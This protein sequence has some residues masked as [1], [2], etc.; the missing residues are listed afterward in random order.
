MNT[1]EI[2]NAIKWGIVIEV[3]NDAGELRALVRHAFGR[4]KVAV[5]IVVSL[6]TGHVCTVWK[7]RGSD[8][9]KTL[10]RTLYTWRTNVIQLIEGISA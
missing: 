9:H 2:L 8:N 7:N 3:H 4:P 1:A 5:C 10:D 6:E